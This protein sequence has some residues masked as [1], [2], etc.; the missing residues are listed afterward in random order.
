VSIL[1]AATELGT[2]VRNCICKQKNML[3]L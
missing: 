3:R 1:F 2:D